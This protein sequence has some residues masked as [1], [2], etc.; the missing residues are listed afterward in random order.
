[1]R[2]IREE[3]RVLALGALVLL[4]CFTVACQDKATVAEL[5][6]CKVQA[7]VEEQ[8]GALVRRIFDELN[9]RHDGI[10]QELYA[11]EY[12]WHFP[13][14]N[15]K[16]LNR[17]EE[18]GFVKLV[19]A[20]FPDIHW[21]VKEVIARD[22]TIVARFIARGT[23]KGRFQGLLPTGN[24][25]ETGGVWT[26]RI[27]NGKVVEAREESDVLGWMQQLGMELKPKEPQK[28]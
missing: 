26:G 27:K 20:G 2:R 22:D 12:G 18:A 6:K 24:T 13:S 7:A 15:P 21:D 3:S 10:Y 11:P 4:L 8:N 5:E 17:E 16:A 9:R 25:F 23:H 14:N 19:W 1:M 28:K